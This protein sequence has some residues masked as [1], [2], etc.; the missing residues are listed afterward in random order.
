MS[1]GESRVSRT[2]P[3]RPGVRLVL[4]NLCCG[5][6][7]LFTPLC[8]IC[9]EKANDRLD[10]SRD[11]VLFAFRVDPEP[12]FAGR[13]GR[14]RAYARDPGPCQKPRCLLSAERPDEVL[15]RGAC[16]KRYAV[17]L[18]GLQAQ[19]YFLLTLRRRNRLVGRWDD[20]LGARLPELLRQDLTRHLGPR[21][22]DAFSSQRMRAEGLDQGLCPVLLRDQVDPQP[23]LL[24][25]L[26]RCRADGGDLR[27]PWQGA[28]VEPVVLQALQ[29]RLDAVHASKDDK[30]E[31]VKVTDRRVERSE[32]FGGTYLYGRELVDLGPQFLQTCGKF[33]SLRP[34]ARDDHPTP[35]ERTPLVPVEPL[36]AQGDDVSDDD[37]RRRLQT[38]LGNPIRDVLKGSRD[39]SLFRYG[40]PPDAGDRRI[41][42][43]AS[44][45]EP[46]RDLLQPAYAHVQ[47]ECVGAV[48]QIFPV[49]V[50]AAF[51]RVLVSRDER[52]ACRDVSVGDGY[53]G[54]CGGCDTARHAGDD[55]E[56]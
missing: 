19:G 5:N 31:R 34:R 51:G 35:E 55:L 37:D 7:I 17:Y 32:V 45:D 36:F 20:D 16:R 29:E 44:R 38:G 11:S 22:E 50:L 48:G 47:N 41:R 53:A 12:V 4:L 23:G 27:F 42:V 15:H 10:E 21:D 46:F 18:S 40:A 1:S 30:A 52:D 54:V 2:S 14:N 6:A 3:R 26:C 43:S 9:S 33:T 8:R 28:K 49:D 13:V 25:P 24:Y 39:G 56:G